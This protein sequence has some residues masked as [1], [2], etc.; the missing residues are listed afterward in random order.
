MNYGAR[1]VIN[2]VHTLAVQILAES[3]IRGDIGKKCAPCLIYLFNIPH[4]YHTD[5]WLAHLYINDA[6]DVDLAK[7]D[8]NGELKHF[9][10]HHT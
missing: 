3:Q 9:V 2:E 8:P 10:H 4:I 7:E 1:S 5:S 6:G